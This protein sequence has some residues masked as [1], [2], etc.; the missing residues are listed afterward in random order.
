MGLIVPALRLTMLFLNIYDSYKTLKLPA[1]SHRNGGKPSQRALTQRKR[2]MKG[3]LAVWIVWCCFINYER[4][5]EAIVSLF[6]PFYDEFKTIVL[7]FFI[8]TRARGAEPIFLH[9]LR[10]LLK[11]YTPTLDMLL[12]FVCMIGDMIFTLAKMPINSI[13]ALLPASIFCKDESPR[14]LSSQHLCHTINAHGKMTMFSP[15]RLSQTAAE[16]VSSGSQFSIS[17]NTVSEELKNGLLPL[18]DDLVAEQTK[19]EYD[20][21]R[22]YPPLPSAYPTTPLMSLSGLPA[23]TGVSVPTSLPNISEDSPFSQSLLSRPNPG[24]SNGNLSRARSKYSEDVLAYPG[25]EQDLDGSEDEDEFNTTLRTPLPPHYLDI[26]AERELPVAA[27]IKK[28][29]IKLTTAGL[30]STRNN[31]SSE[32]LSS[33]ALSVS[34]T[35]TRGGKRLSADKTFLVKYGS[36]FVNGNSRTGRGSS[37][38][39]GEGHGLDTKVVVPKR[40]TVTSPTRTTRPQFV[41]NTTGTSKTQKTNTTVRNQGLKTY[42]RIG[43]VVFNGT[44]QSRQNPPK[45]SSKTIG[46]AKRRPKS[47][48]SDTE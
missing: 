44:S 34:P 2:D 13:K 30:G 4:V 27:Q 15:K 11:P 38:V 16:A 25:S 9:V 33:T 40:R 20:E 48:S 46:V 29:S 21:W 26:P 1:P 5:A 8:F 19:R 35:P 18:V 12:D 36:Q 23:Y 3:C 32:S 45:Y 42:D 22:Q 6:V 37:K 28:Q 43:T 24:L 47:L 39:N 31:S 14:K 7:L 41:R 10:P 17:G